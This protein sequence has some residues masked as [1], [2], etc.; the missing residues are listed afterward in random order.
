MAALC[1]M[2][3]MQHLARSGLLSVNKLFTS[4]IQRCLMS[5]A[6]DWVMPASSAMLLIFNFKFRSAF[7]PRRSAGPQRRT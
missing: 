3:T 5:R 2:P 4:C 7:L 1:G 6:C